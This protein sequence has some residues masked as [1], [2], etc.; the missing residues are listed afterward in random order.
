[1]SKRSQAWTDRTLTRS[2]SNMSALLSPVERQFVLNSDT[3]THFLETRKRSRRPWDASRLL[4][5]RLSGSVFLREAA[6]R[7]HSP[8]YPTM[9]S[10]LL[11]H[12]SPLHHGAEDISAK[13]FV[14]KCQLSASRTGRENFQLI[15]HLS[16]MILVYEHLF[17]RSLRDVTVKR[18]QIMIHYYC[19]CSLGNSPP[20]FDQNVS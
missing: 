5:F 14:Y 17:Q 13:R 16:R 10:P 12:S 19:F 6:C 1:M 18:H 7:A 2:I 9:A 20:V 8:L 15:Q 3:Y 11:V 4:H